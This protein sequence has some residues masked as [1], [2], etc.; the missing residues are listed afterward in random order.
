MTPDGPPLLPPPPLRVRLG[1]CSGVL[2]AFGGG[3]EAD[4]DALFECVSDA[5]Q[6]G[7]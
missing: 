3:H 5:L 1:G 2:Q 7:Q 6:H 4:F